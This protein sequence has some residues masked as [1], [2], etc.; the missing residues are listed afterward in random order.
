[1]MEAPSQPTESRA[2]VSWN[3]PGQPI[4]IALRGPGG[5]VSMPLSPTR[6]LEMAKQ[7]IEP[8]VQAIKSSQWGEDWPS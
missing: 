2:I 5:E 8:A 7:L 3:G 1:M 4:M 6:A